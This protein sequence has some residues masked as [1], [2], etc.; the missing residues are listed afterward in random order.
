MPDE[1]KKSGWRYFKYLQGDIIDIGCGN[2]PVLPGVEQYDIIHGSG[3]AQFVDS[4][5][6][7]RYDSV[8]SSHTLEHVHNPLEALLNW[9]RILKTGGHLVVMIPEEDLYEQHVWPPIWNDDHKKT[10]AIHKDKSWSP[11]HINVLD[12]IKHLPNHKLILIE[13]L[14]QGYDYSLTDDG[15]FDQ[16]AMPTMAEAGIGFVLK[17]INPSDHLDRKSSVKEPFIC[18]DCGGEFIVTGQLDDGCFGI[19]CTTCKFVG[20]MKLN[21]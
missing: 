11:Q 10:F 20:K 17:K 14:D 5:S 8:Y 3:D 6:D 9:W 1:S 16:T 19:R 15:P 21:N 18:G 2:D 12:L 7:G 13:T 4:L